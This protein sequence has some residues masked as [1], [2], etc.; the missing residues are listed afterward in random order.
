MPA[1]GLDGP[2]PGVV[3]VLDL[4]PGASRL[5]CDGAQMRSVFRNLINNACDAMPTGGRLT[6]S[7][8]GTGEGEEIWFADSGIGV[9]AGHL[10][11]VFEPF[12]TTRSAVTH[13]T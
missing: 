7:T 4:D 12:F 1:S 8:L 2:T 10:E 11:K 9:P 3:P 6:I 13:S 5:L